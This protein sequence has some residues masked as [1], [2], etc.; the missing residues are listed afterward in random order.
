[1]NPRRRSKICSVP[2]ALN[3]THLGVAYRVTAWPDVQ[4]ERLYGSEWI[5]IAP[6][7]EAMASAS[8]SLDAAAWNSYVDFVPADVREFLVEYSF[9]RMEAL[10]VIARCPSLLPT[11]QATPGLTAFVAAH[12]TLRAERDPRWS[13]LETVHDRSGVFGLLEWLGLPAS[14]Q[15]LDVLHHLA[16]PDVPKRLLEPLR[17]ALWEPRTLFAL[18]REAELTDRLL[19]KYCHA[20]AA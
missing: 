15:T 18:Q 1:M 2:L 6:S 16:S 8:Q 14:R 12:V 19:E 10:Q 13:E 7:V 4:F 9:I 5:S 3:W 20:L 17:S 11:L